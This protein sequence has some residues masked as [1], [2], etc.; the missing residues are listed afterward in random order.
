M[1]IGRVMSTVKSHTTVGGSQ[2]ILHRF[3]PRDGPVLDDFGGMVAGRAIFQSISQAIA[4]SH[5]T[6][7]ARRKYGLGVVLDPQTQ[8]N[9]SHPSDRVPSFIRTGYSFDI[10]WQPEIDELSSA[11]A[12]WYAEA[13]VAAQHERYATVILSPYHASGRI[14]TRGRETDLILA[15]RASDYFFGSSIAISQT[16]GESELLREFWVTISIDPRARDLDLDALVAEYSGL[17]C[18][19]YWIRLDVNRAV[20]H[21]D[22]AVIAYVSHQLKART[23]RTIGIAGIG[24]LGI[25]F[26]ASGIDCVLFGNVGPALVQMPRPILGS[27]LHSGYLRNF[28]PSSRYGVAAFLERPCGCGHHLATSPPFG[29]ARSRHTLS[30]EIREQFELQGRDLDNASARMR[31]RVQEVNE[32]ADQIGARR[33]DERSWAEPFDAALLVSGTSRSEAEE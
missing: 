28:A 7:A 23:T 2:S 30:L 25:A 32:A 29:R 3:G 11:T 13:V 20:S 14:G 33:L 17:R 10:G 19:G 24:P 18:D 4:N 22:V 31:S 8:T 15:E 6:A 1:L 21:E 9:L 5:V 26:A 27:V 16:N 12:R